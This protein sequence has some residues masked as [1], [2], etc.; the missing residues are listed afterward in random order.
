MQLTESFDES[1][2]KRKVLLVEGAE[3]GRSRSIALKSA[4]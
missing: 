1:R 2:S 3:L 4:A